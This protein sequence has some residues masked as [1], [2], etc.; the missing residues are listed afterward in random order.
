M[1]GNLLRNLGQNS[2][3]TVFC[4]VPIFS[5]FTTLFNA[6]FTMKSVP[7]WSVCKIFI[8]VWNVSAEIFASF[9]ISPSFALSSGLIFLKKVHQ[10]RSTC[11]VLRNP[12]QGLEKSNSR[13]IF[14]GMK[15]RHAKHKKRSAL[16]LLVCTQ[17]MDS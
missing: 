15:Q 12:T 8:R 13:N 9:L 14:S 2:C 7:I 11:N 3:S 4:Y 6:V 1:Q 16:L 5:H 17:K 10:I